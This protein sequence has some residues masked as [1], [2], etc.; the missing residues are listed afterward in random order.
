M[1]ASPGPVRRRFR[2]ERFEFGRMGVMAAGAEIISPLSCARKG[3]CSLAMNPY[4][5]A[6]VEVAVALSAEPVAFLEI[7][8]FVVIQAQFVAVFG[9]MAIEAPS[10]RLGVMEL[11]VRMFLFQLSLGSMGLHGGVAAAAREQPLRHRRRSNLFNHAVCRG[12]KKTHEQEHERQ[13][14][15][16][17]PHPQFLPVL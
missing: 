12:G 8:E 4:S 9:V 3:P 6:L 13:P 10:H 14:I 1:M 17:S 5:P 11:D 15:D 2:F 7:D 16:S